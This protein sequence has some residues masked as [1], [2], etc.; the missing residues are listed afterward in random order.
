VACIAPLI[1]LITLFSSAAPADQTDARLD[2]LF[3]TLQSSANTVVLRETELSIWEIW[4]E[5]DHQNVDTLMERGGEAVTSGDLDA[6]EEIF[7]R[8][9]DMAPQF[10]E[11]WNRRAT[12]R[13]YR[14]D[15]ERSLDD[16]Q[17]TLALEPR[18]FGSSNCY[19]LNPATRRRGT[20]SNC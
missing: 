20:A 16:I 2:K 9:I 1:L 13:Y 5:S 8:V 4:F 10:S 15:Y 19:A 17:R 3:A 11:G 6:A 12:V 18:H 7:T 14:L